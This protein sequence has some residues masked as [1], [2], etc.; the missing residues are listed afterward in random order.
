MRLLQNIPIGKDKQ[1]IVQLLA[2]DKYYK[3]TPKLAH[4]ELHA[5]NE[6]I[7]LSRAL[8][9]GDVNAA[10]GLLYS[11]E[12]PRQMVNENIPLSSGVY[13]LLNM[14]SPLL[15]DAT[16]RQALQRGTDTSEL[17][18]K[19]GVVDF[20][21]D[22]PYIPQ[23]IQTVAAPQKTTA[24]VAE[25]AAMLD[26]AG[27]KLN[28]A[29]RSKG[30]VKL[31]LRV[32]AVKDTRY[33]AVI[34]ELTRQWKKLGVEVEPLVFDPQATQQSFAQVVLQPRAYDVLVNELLIG[35][36]GDVF[37][38]WH[39]TQAQA[40]GYNFSNYQNGLVD[41]TLSSAR[42]TSD[43]TVRS[44]KYAVFGEQWLKDVPAIGLF[45]SALRYAHTKTAVGVDTKTTM[46]TAVDR[47]TDVLYWTAEMGQVYKTP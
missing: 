8:T 24:N 12:I 42:T 4:F 35:G 25:A 5:Y 16:L 2:W 7:S 38:Y 39:S 15:A 14:K 32:A 26:N 1:K 36:D 33:T 28:G 30:D 43:P 6:Q 40:A 11:D 44:R 10:A 47:Y 3:G 46:P 41:D 29:Y 22:L 20:A 31:K 9:S 21:L 37:A 19:I 23:Q 17:R 27:W 45:Q 13:A 18:K 34:D